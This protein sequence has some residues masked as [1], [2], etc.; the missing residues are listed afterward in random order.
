MES[1]LVLSTME[2]SFV[3]GNGVVKMSKIRVR[4]LWYHICFKSMRR[5]LMIYMMI[6]YVIYGVGLCHT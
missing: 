2:L 4:F 3:D 5:W 6:A 1:F